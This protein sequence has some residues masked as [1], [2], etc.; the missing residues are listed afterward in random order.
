MSRTAKKDPLVRVPTSH[1]E[2]VGAAELRGNLAKYLRHAKA[3][4]AVIIQ[5]RGRTAY[6]LVRFA[7]EPAASVFGCMR[8]RTTYTRGAVVNAAPSEWGPGEMP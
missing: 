6:V 5:E 2:R 8:E 4:R 7:E 3:G 1:A